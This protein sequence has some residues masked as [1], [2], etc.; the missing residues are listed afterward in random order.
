MATGKFPIDSNVPLPPNRKLVDDPDYELIP[1]D[2]LEDYLQGLSADEL[3]RII[4]KAANAGAFS[5]FRRV[6]QACG[7]LE[8]RD[9]SDPTEPDDI[10]TWPPLGPNVRRP[11]KKGTKK[12]TKKGATKKTSRK[13]GKK[14]A[15]KG[16]KRR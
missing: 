2:Q 16:S 5:I 8:P 14:A 6:T 1:F 11:G 15:K 12:T 10:P 13:G 4:I 9:G 3:I 7:Q